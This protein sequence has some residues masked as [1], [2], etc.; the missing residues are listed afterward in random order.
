MMSVPYV[1]LA[2]FCA[3]GLAIACPVI[4]LQRF[5]IRA[6]RRMLVEAGKEISER[7]VA[8]QECVRERDACRTALDG[9]RAQR[10]D[11]LAD[12]VRALITFL[13]ARARELEHEDDWWKHGQH[14]DDEAPDA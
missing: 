11:E 8:V 7:D 12:A 2:L 10:L 4:L 9:V 13:Q 3:I 6:Q 14:P 5:V 1:C